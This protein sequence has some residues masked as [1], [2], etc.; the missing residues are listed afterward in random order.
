MLDTA[1]FIS[2]WEGAVRMVQM[3]GAIMTHPC[4]IIFQLSDATIAMR[5][6]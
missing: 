5:R 2:G 3:A 6:L 4:V 1:L